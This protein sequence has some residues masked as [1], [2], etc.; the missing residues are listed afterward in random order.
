MSHA[1]TQDI[2]RSQIRYN[3][4]RLAWPV[5]VE[6]GLITLVQIFDMMMVGHLGV[7]ALNAIGLT[8]QPLM[9][10]M[11]IFNGLSVGTTA[12]IARFIGERNREQ[13]SRTFQQSLLG[14]TFLASLMSIVLYF[15]AP[16]ILVIMGAETARVVK[17]G[18]GYIRWLIPGLF[19]QWIFIVISAALRGAGDTK[20]PMYVNI[21]I[22]IINIL[23]NYLLIFG[24]WIFPRMEVYGAGLATSIARI[25]GFILLVIL[26]HHPETILKPNWKEFF[27]IDWFIMKRIIRIGIPA[28][29]EQAILRIGQTLYTRVVSTLGSVAFAAHTT[30][31]NAESISYMPGWG[32]SVAATTMVGQKLGEG[33]PDE[34]EASGIESLKFGCGVMAFMGI[35]FLIFPEFLMRLYI[36]MSDPNARE[37]IYL[38]ARNLRIVALA[39]IPMATQFILAGGLRG[40]GYTKPV[41]YSTMIGVWAGRL[42]SAYVFIFHFG[43]GLVG[44]WIAMC[45]DWFLRSAYVVY[46]WKKG[47]WKFTEI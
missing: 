38:G 39:Q 10:G 3:I 35:I 40:A 21:V 13:A 37:L 24:V 8:L 27:K 44:A 6:M 29:L 31:I 34:A 30:A 22:N 33:K 11:I 4:L 1:K 12:L 46:L 41:L 26:L 43:W 42:L 32:F 47:E 9:L 17:L 36:D 18:A 5:I 14:S 7:D 28:T 20:T 15:I 45:I 19:L 25:T 2:S 23:G 16:H